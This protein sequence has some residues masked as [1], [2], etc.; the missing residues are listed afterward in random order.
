MRPGTYVLGPDTASLIVH[1]RRQG[2]AAKAGH[3]LVIEVT[4]WTATLTLGEAPALELSADSRSLEIRQGV[5]GAKPL[6]DR[7]RRDIRR[8]IDDKVLGGAPIGFVSTSVSN[9]GDGTLAV[10]GDL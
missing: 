6:T 5:G 7:D 10:E 9:A 8:N 2:L 3:D 4:R 1:T